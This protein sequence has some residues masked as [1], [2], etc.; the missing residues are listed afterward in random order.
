MKINVNL[1]GTWGDFG[2]LAGVAA[3]HVWCWGG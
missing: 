2:A 1:H 3:M